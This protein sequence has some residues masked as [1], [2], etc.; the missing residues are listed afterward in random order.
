MLVLELKQIIIRLEEIFLQRPRILTLEIFWFTN[1]LDQFV[2]YAKSIWNIFLI[3]YSIEILGW[4]KAQFMVSLLKKSLSTNTDIIQVPIM[5]SNAF[6]IFL[7]EYSKKVRE[8]NML[9]NS[10]AQRS[11]FSEQIVI[12]DP[13]V[14][15]DLYD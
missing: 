12:C 13:K 14:Y 6:H 5:G 9:L 3:T 2:W 10:F 1:L 8:V 11:I 15:F 4:N 7:F